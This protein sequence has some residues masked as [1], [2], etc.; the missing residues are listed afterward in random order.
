[1]IPVMYIHL[2]LYDHCHRHPLSRW[3]KTSASQILLGKC[4]WLL[5]A[6]VPI[7][8]SQPARQSVAFGVFI[9][10]GA[11]CC[12]PRVKK[13]KAWNTLTNLGLV[14]TNYT[15]L[16]QS[17]KWEN[18]W[19]VWFFFKDFLSIFRYQTQ[20]IWQLLPCQQARLGVLDVSMPWQCWKHRS[21]L[22]C[23]RILNFQPHPSVGSQPLNGCC[24]HR[25]SGSWLIPQFFMSGQWLGHSAILSTLRFITSRNLQRTSHPC[26]HIATLL[27]CRRQAP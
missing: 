19:S 25:C 24:P 16:H 22:Q 7:F 15:K 3:K 5:P 18:E 21:T 20:K 13:N 6:Q 10:V 1:M 27:L 2:Q 8:D 23:F 9:C 26:H 11:A 17:W 12:R 4:P 14:W